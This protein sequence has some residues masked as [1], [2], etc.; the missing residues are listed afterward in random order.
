[1]WICGYVLKL[2]KQKCLGST[3][4]NDVSCSFLSIWQFFFGE[5][6]VQLPTY[7]HS[8]KRF[9]FFSCI[10]NGLSVTCL[11]FM[12][13]RIYIMFFIF[14]KTMLQIVVENSYWLTSIVNSSTVIKHYII[15]RN[16][17][18]EKLCFS[19]C[20]RKMMYVFLILV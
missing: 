15:S 19:F 20:A 10:K 9:S 4:V 5:C 3:D 14:P 8:L 13:F 12:L 1:V 2:H 11:S 7:F 18:C 16:K 6:F 17:M